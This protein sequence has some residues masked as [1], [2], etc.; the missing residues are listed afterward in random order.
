M[1]D[2]DLG[3]A[4][5][6]LQRAYRD[7]VSGLLADL[8]H[9]ARGYQTLAEVA[10]GRQRSQAALA[11]HLG[12]DR[13]VMTYLIDD[14]E[15][16]GLVERQADP[17]DRRQRRVV[18]TA[19]GEAAIAALCSRVAAAEDATMSGLDDAERAQL[20]LLLAKAARDCEDAQSARMSARS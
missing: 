13:T 7:R 20:R 1:E 10:T 9:G 4:L 3:W 11:Q 6:V 18:I 5:G 12:I 19:Q 14:L 17:E 16:A 2:T 8:P 15:G